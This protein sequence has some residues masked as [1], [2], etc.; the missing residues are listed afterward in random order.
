ML[1]PV[2]IDYDSSNESWNVFYIEVWNSKSD[3]GWNVQPFAFQSLGHAMSFLQ[4]QIANP[5]KQVR[6]GGE[7]EA[8]LKP[9]SSLDG[10]VVRIRQL[11]LVTDYEPKCPAS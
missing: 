11:I 7:W 1:S 2:P 10:T 8:D 4:S 5:L 9:H 6:P 3:R